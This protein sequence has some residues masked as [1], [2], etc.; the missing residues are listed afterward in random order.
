M[1]RGLFAPAAS[2]LRKIIEY[3]S[4]EQSPRTNPR[5]YWRERV[6]QITLLSLVAFTPIA[7]VFS[8]A[9]AVQLNLESIAVIDVV[10]YAWL[11]YLTFARRLRY[12]TRVV[13]LLSMGFILSMAL[14]YIAG[15]Q[16]SA[17][18]WMLLPIA[19]AAL[20][21][22]RRQALVIFALIMLTMGV[23]TGMSYLHML[24]STNG[25]AD[26]P[27]IWVL[28]WVN[29]AAIGLF[30]ALSVSTVTDGLERAF[31][32]E[33]TTSK[34]LQE[35]RARLEE[36]TRRLREEAKRRNELQDQL[37]QSQK[38]EAL[39]RLA[40]GVAHDLNNL[41]VP[42]MGNAELMKYELD[43]DSENRGRLNDILY[44]SNRARLL[45][46][47]LLAFGRKQKLSLEHSDINQVI[48]T[49][50]RL[51]SRTI[52]ENIAIDLDLAPDLEPLLVDRALFE[53]VLLNLTLNA[54]DAVHGT[55]TI[56]IRTARVELE[57][58]TLNLPDPIEPGPYLE[59]TIADTG[60]GIEKEL[61]DKLFEPFFTTKEK[62]KGTGL[63]LSTVYG[64]VKQHDGAIT[65]ES[66]PGEG[67]VFRVYL[68]FSGVYEPAGVGE[69]EDFMQPYR[70]S[71][72]VLVVEDDEKVRDIMIKLLNTAGYDA[73]YWG[74]ATEA[75]EMLRLSPQDIKLLVTDIV[76]PDMDGFQTY[77]EMRAIQADLKV[78]FV[79]GYTDDILNEQTDL[80]RSLPLLRKPFMY[81][82]FIH[83]VETALAMEP[84]ALEMLR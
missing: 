37:W 1:K 17:Q 43:L 12:T 64:I 9:L 77:K 21:L 51:M 45:V 70:G 71:G 39:G 50:N 82:D 78:L 4:P 41:L 10:L 66:N 73:I 34:R 55:G 52:P 28:I 22:G 32:L 44:A 16:S 61:L 79:S 54:R 48:V 38:V 46:H 6:L 53:Q 3:R 58:G 20:L 76:M 25:I 5:R 57:A 27:D 65:V 42:V 8:V 13:H 62:G 63:G 60:K 56:T 11:L 84:D 68:P 47:Q 74:S 35:E 33:H 29:M 31:L 7:L 19:A 24:P 40:G 81:K 80:L 72:T 83:H 49:F 67:T 69:E 15:A 36:I 18:A 26:N 75:V 59:L 2:V 14:M 23:F 30:L